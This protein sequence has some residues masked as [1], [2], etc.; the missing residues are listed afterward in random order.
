M[1]DA[2]AA[3][4]GGSQTSP[5]PSFPSL[6]GAQNVTRRISS[7]HTFLFSS[8]YGPSQKDLITLP[9]PQSASL[10]VCLTR[11]RQVQYIHHHPRQPPAET[12]ADGASSIVQVPQ[13]SLTLSSIL[14][15]ACLPC[16][17]TANTNL[18]GPSIPHTL[19]SHPGCPRLSC[20][21]SSTT[22][23]IPTSYSR[24]PFCLPV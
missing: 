5:S 2:V 12:R 9:R 8:L 20:C 24:P 13:P 17:V 1:S 14:Q 18:S 23:S 10:S 16:S 15:I 11:G 21:Y 3:P 6:C 4:L 19:P 7:S 22:L